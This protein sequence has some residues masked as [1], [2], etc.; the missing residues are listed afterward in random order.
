MLVNDILF[1]MVCTVMAISHFRIDTR[2]IESQHMEQKFLFVLHVYLKGIRSSNEPRSSLCSTFF[3]TDETLI[4]CVISFWHSST[5]LRC[6]AVTTGASF[7]N[8]DYLQSQHPTWIS[9]HMQS[10]MWDVISYPFPNFNCCT[11]EVWKW[12]TNFISHFVKDVITY[13][14]WDWS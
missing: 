6:N 3:M 7:T 12:I 14:C 10:K 4:I 13:P 8:T 9:N 11:V 1:N 5:M 2:G